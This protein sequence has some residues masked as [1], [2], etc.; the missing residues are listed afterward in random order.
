[1][2]FAFN[3][4]S[5]NFLQYRVSRTEARPQKQGLNGKVRFVRTEYGLN[6][7]YWFLMKRSLV[8]A[9]A[10]LSWGMSS[11]ANA[12]LVL[13]PSGTLSVPAAS[14]GVSFTF[15]GT[16]TGS[17]QLGFSESGLACL[18]PGNT[19]CTNGAGVVVTPGSTGT[20]GSLA[21][22]ATTFGALLLNI[23]GVAGTVKLFPTNSANGLGSST[24]PSVLF[25]SPASLS[26]LGFGTFSVSNPTLTFSVS[27]TFRGDNSGGFTL[28]QA[29]VTAVPE[30]ASLALLGIGV[31][32]FG[33]MRKRRKN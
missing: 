22:G 9:L 5:Q 19:F 28:T 4:I 13:L 3:W 29:A 32:A 15:T 31:A 30:P 16:L 6:I 2:R 14:N 12:A 27:D 11:A 33:A 10:V 21:N 17:D 1:M 23:S 18:Q 26:S 24:P 7:D 25:L 20:G 8:L